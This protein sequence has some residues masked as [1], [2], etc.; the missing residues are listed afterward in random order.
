ML[1][2]SI[3]LTQKRV[4]PPVWIILVLHAE[5]SSV[6]A[7]LSKA[8]ITLT[9]HPLSRSNLCVMCLLTF[10]VARTHKKQKS[11]NAN[12]NSHEHIL[13][14]SRAPTNSHEH[15]STAHAKNRQSPEKNR[16]SQIRSPLDPQSGCFFLCPVYATRCPRTSSGKLVVQVM[17]YGIRRAA[18]FVD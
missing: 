5:L 11:E 6:R 18:E 15:I 2:F 3:T 17:C 13:S 10:P 1:V 9:S 14:T 8:L 4:R 7:L 16:Q 12:T